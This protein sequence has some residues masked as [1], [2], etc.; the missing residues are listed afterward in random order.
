[1][2]SPVVKRFVKS[3]KTLLLKSI[4][5]YSVDFAYK[6]GVTAYT[7]KWNADKDGS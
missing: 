3:A 4:E 1:M 6:D 7:G 2:R 5:I